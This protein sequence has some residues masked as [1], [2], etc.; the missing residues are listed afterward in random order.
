[1]DPNVW[2]AALETVDG[3]TWSRG[4]AD[5]S[6]S[7]QSTSKPLTYCY[8][9]EE[10]G[11]ETVH[12]YIG[13]EPSGKAFNAFKLNDSGQPFN[14]FINTGAIATCSIAGRGLSGSE[15]Y[16]KVHKF[17]SDLAGGQKLGFSN[18]IYLSEKGTA[19]RNRALAYFMAESGVFPEGTDVEEALDVY[20]QTC[21]IE[22]TAK[23]LATMAATLA[24]GGIN[25]TTGVRVLSSET[26]AN[27][28][29]LLMSCGM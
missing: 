25:P 23:K 18:S 14:P 9:C 13:R 8:V 20:F 2:A 15:R 12:G 22:V 19:D 27:C 29:V 3:H 5:L 10:L 7:L 21:S 26:V 4:E 6:F 11:A 24:N 16:R 28:M 17:F 1:M